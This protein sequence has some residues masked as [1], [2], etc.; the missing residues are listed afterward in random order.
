MDDKPG[1]VSLSFSY[2]SIAELLVYKV[3]QVSDAE[4]A[5]GVTE[6]VGAQ[7]EQGQQTAA[8]RD[9]AIAELTQQSGSYRNC[10]DNGR[11][12]SQISAAADTVSEMAAEEQH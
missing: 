7:V 10:A 8:Q 11:R 4:V 5:A 9:E 3:I 12:D 2:L 6:Q 1:V